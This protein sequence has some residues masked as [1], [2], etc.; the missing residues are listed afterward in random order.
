MFGF[1]ATPQGYT[2]RLDDMERGI[3]LRLVGDIAALIDEEHDDEDRAGEPPDGIDDPIA[4]L[5]FEPSDS[6]DATHD[7]HELVDPALSRLFPPMSVSDPALADEMRSLT[8]EDLRRSKVANLDLVR[9]ALAHGAAAV[10]VRSGEEAQWLAA[11]TD[12]RLVLAARLGIENDDD[13]RQVY[14]LAVAATQDESPAAS[15][16][17][18]MRMAMASLYSGITWWQESLLRAVTAPGPAN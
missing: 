14:D 7:E 10:T 4:H 6:R 8:V 5:D 1:V 17:D 13:S 3:L 18:E 16:D 15:H 12:I 2:S 9:D 11:L